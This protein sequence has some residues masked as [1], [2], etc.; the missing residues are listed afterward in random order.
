[1]RSREKSKLISS[2]NYRNTVKTREAEGKSEFMYLPYAI[3]KGVSGYFLRVEFFSK[4]ER[5]EF[6]STTAVDEEE[7]SYF[8]P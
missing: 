6:V 8:F 4:G 2:Q 3:I 1:M 5:I 7:F